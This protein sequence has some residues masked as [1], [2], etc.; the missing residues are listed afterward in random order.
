VRARHEFAPTRITAE[1]IESDYT[2]S[3]ELRAL[4]PARYDNIVLLGS[5]WT[6]SG[7]ESDARTILGCLL[8]RE[9]LPRHG[10]PAIL[11]EL[12]D[13][14]NVS[15]FRRRP[16]EVIITPRILS[17]MLAQVALRQELRS[18]FDELF[19]PAGPEIVFR[20]AA[21][22]DVAGTDIN[23]EQIAEQARAHGEIALGVRP[24]DARRERRGG[25]VLN[26]P[27]DRCWTLNA[28]DEIV[29]ITHATWTAAATAKGADVAAA[30]SVER[31]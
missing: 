20:R 10:G 1:L 5:D 19:G 21:A 11:V 31:T 24:A 25:I 14:A 27:R 22:Y 2:V 8:L 4:E 9:L 3:S 28:A 17:H 23:F 18:V 7:E 13:E 15:L 26:P 29:A 6:G 12:L 16:V 30:I